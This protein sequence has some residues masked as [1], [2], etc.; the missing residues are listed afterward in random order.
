MIIDEM[1][2][3]ELTEFGREVKRLLKNRPQEWLARQAGVGQSTISRLL[4]GKNVPE[5]KTIEKIAEV[6][7]VDPRHLL[8]LA[9]VPVVAPQRHQT[10]E[11]IAQQLHDLPPYLQEHAFEIIGATVETFRKIN[12]GETAN[13]G[14]PSR[15]FHG[16]FIDGETQEQIVRLCLLVLERGL[17][18]EP[19]ET[20][21]P[22]VEAPGVSDMGKEGQAH[23][24]AA[25]ELAKALLGAIKKS[26]EL[27]EK[28]ISKGQSRMQMLESSETT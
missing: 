16:R 21:E 1:A 6:L 3:A 11:Y 15:I 8:A 24:T 28:A 20:E 9:G 22:L 14:E 17:N 27:A 4:H 13:G 26:T 23:D 2:T 10:A 12:Q 19:E 7:E 25:M 18:D 5:T